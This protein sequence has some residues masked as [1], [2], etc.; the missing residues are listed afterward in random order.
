[1]QPTVTAAS[2][3][4]QAADTTA[5]FEPTPPAQVATAAGEQQAATPTAEAPLPDSKADTKPTGEARPAPVETVQPQGPQAGAGEESLEPIEPLL[6]A[7]PEP[8]SRFTLSKPV[9]RAAAGSES[10]YIRAQRYLGAGRL[11]EAETALRETLEGAPNN[12]K[13]RELLVGLLVRGGRGAEALQLLREGTALAPHRPGFALLQSRI[14]MQ[15]GD[16]SGAV[17]LLEEVLQ[18]GNANREVVSLLAVLYQQ[19]KRH[20]RALEMY[21][22]LIEREPGLASNWVGAAISLEALGNPDEALSAYRRAVNSPN[23]AQ[24]LRAYAKDRIKIL[25]QN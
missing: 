16:N 8:S 24:A 10:S 17:S 13:A 9:K 11:A 21:R 22:M 4:P 15:R 5:V 25:G 1:M 20:E 19:Q 2:D 3:A 18:S 14:L 23:L 7:G 6:D 12:H